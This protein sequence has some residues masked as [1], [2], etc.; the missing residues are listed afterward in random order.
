[1]SETQTLKMSRKYK[2]RNQDQ[3]YFISFATV[4]WIDAFTRRIYKDVVVDSFNYCI[5]EK[6]LIVYAWVIMTNHVHAIIGTQ[7]EKLQDI[8]RDLKK[9]TSKE[10]IKEIKDNPQESRKEWMLWMFK[11]AGEK[12]GNN[13]KYQFW[14][15]HNQPLVISNPIA[16]EQKL[17]YIHLNPV[18]AGFVN[19]AEEY[20][21]SSA[22]DYAGGKGYVDICREM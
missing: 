20:A 13:K 11:R 14:Q 5:N 19:S 12:N 4:Y 7:G 9:H 3:T 15:Q 17:N 18:E 2:F 21:Y 22:V 16:Y 6:G 8:L 10:L 1:M